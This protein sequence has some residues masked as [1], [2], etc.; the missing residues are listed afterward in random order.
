M[1]IG[2]I[3]ELLEIIKSNE[4]AEFEMEKKDFVVRI[5]TQPEEMVAVP[6]AQPV[7]SAPAPA[8]AAPAPEATP[9]AEPSA[10]DDGLEVIT[11]PMVGTFYRAPS[12]DTDPFVAQGSSVGPETVVCIIEAMKVMNEIQSEISG[13][14]AEIL[15]KDGAPVEFGQP[16][17]KVKA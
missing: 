6:Q 10:S 14:I 13:T 11:S 4:I 2:E 15:V 1:N 9:A 12:P 5:R 8:P 17:F 16:L 7:Y 3:K